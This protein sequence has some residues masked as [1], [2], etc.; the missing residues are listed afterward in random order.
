MDFASDGLLRSPCWDFFNLVLRLEL[1]MGIPLVHRRDIF[2]RNINWPYG[3][4]ML[5]LKFP[6]GHVLIFLCITFFRRHSLFGTSFV[7]KTVASHHALARYELEKVV[8]YQA[9]A[10]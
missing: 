10:R 3:D 9:H 5:L 7:E 6:F 2:H 1:V 8:A 4:W